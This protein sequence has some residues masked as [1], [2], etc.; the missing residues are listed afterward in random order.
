MSSLYGHGGDP[1]YTSFKLQ[2]C[3]CNVVLLPSTCFL[4]WGLCSHVLG[5]LCLWGSA[6][7][8]K[9]VQQGFRSELAS[10]VGFARAGEGLFAAL[11]LHVS[12]HIWAVWI[13]DKKT[14]CSPLLFIFFSLSSLLYLFLTL[15]PT[16]IQQSLSIYKSLY[17]Q[18]EIMTKT[19]IYF[20]MQQEPT[21]SG[22]L[23]V[24]L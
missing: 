24:I 17:W 20:L 8:L 19:Y 9:M 4:L 1:S 6:K 10:D 7:V 11:H 21:H 18:L 12:A 16:H 13:Q 23:K 14:S 5:H 15:A 3:S 2:H 22:G